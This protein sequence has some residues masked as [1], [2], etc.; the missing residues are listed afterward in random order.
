[1]FPQA[2][3]GL[4]TNAVPPQTQ[5]ASADTLTRIR[6]ALR[7]FSRISRDSICQWVRVVLFLLL[8]DKWR[9]VH[10]SIHHALPLGYFGALGSFGV[11]FF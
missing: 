9:G 10:E 7:R 1:M 2:R 3:R 5:S 4:T 6:L 11:L 8:P